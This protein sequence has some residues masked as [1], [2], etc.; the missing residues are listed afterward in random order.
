M[1]YRSEFVS[2]QFAIDE[3]QTFFEDEMVF[4]Y[5]ASYHFDDHLSVMFQV[6]NIT[7]TPTKSYFGQ[8]AQT[9][10]IQFFGRQFFLGVNYVM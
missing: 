9:G 1:R 8:K 5:Q 4:D 2:S 3:Q 10:T 7:D 6:I